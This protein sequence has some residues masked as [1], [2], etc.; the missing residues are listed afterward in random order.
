MLYPALLALA[1]AGSTNGN[2]VPEDDG[3]SRQHY[4]RC[5]SPN[6]PDRAKSAGINYGRA[7]SHGRT[8]V[9]GCMGC[10][11]RG[12]AIDLIMQLTH[13]TPADAYRWAE[14]NIDGHANSKPGTDARPSKPAAY[15]PS[16]ADDD[17]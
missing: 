2:D 12:D 13:C 3:T 11:L 6:H 16:F 10:A 7:S 4:V 14:V 8:G 5:I 15:R 1:R 9:Y 17:F